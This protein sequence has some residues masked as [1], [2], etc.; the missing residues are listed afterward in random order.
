MAIWYVNPAIAPA[1]ESDSFLGQ[2]GLGKLRDTWA[3]VTWT[4]GDKYFAAADTV[5]PGQIAL[6]ASGTSGN[7][8]V[9]GMYGN[10]AKPVIGVGVQDALFISARQYIDVSD[11][12]L[13]GSTRHGA[14]IRT[15]GSNITTINLR[16]VKARG[17]SN[18]GFFLDGVVLTA[19]LSNVLFEECEAYDNGEHGF[20]TLGIV[21]S[22][23]W[24]RCVAGR[25]GYR[26]LGHG[27]SLHPFI[28][29]NI[30]SGWT[31]VSGN[32]YSRPTSASENVQKVANI[33]DD[34][35]L[36]KNPGAGASV[37]L[38]QWDQATPGDL[39]Y[40][41]I[42]ANPNTKT[43]AF[44]R[45]PHGP[46]YYEGCVSYENSTK[47]GP[48]EGHGFAAD[49]M[50]DSATYEDCHAYDN[51]GAGLQCQWSDNVVQRNCTASR[52]RL[53][54][55]RTTG[56]TN[57]LTV[58]RCISV[59][60]TDHGFLYDAPHTGVLVRN[61]IAVRNGGFGLIGI[62]AGVTAQNMLTFGNV[63]GGV[64]NVTSTGAVSGDPLFVDESRPWLGLKPG[65]P[66]WRAGAVIQGARDRFGRRYPNPSHI[67]PWAV[68]AR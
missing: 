9:I 41:N 39:L 49:D 16:R 56:H 68:E 6:G 31:L 1:A 17:N 13:R 66:A 58:D 60:N 20:D 25:N 21:Q 35:T 23:N 28:A 64:T 14:Y 26:V 27:F 37:G 22:I 18:N 63:S 40:I 8:I 34:V 38:N 65:S 62:S 32:V 42:G 15:N 51:E 12:D 52:N 29:G 30:T 3:D 24:K 2:Y 7:P 55:F 36:T 67:G 11:L 4:P 43:T 53:S 5:F 33:T 10:G 61:S 54:G 46:F 57:G 47:A 48:G 19:A 44:K 50:S 45:A 59:G